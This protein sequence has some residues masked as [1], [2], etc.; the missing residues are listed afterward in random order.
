MDGITP[1][2]I[3]VIF[4]VIG[5][6]SEIKSDAAKKA[7]KLQKQFVM[8]QQHAAQKAHALRKEKPMPAADFASDDDF[9]DIETMTEEAKPPVEPVPVPDSTDNTD[10]YSIDKHDFSLEYDWKKAIVA[11]EILKTKF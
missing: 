3:A 4:I 2:I 6:V 8:Q 5:I 11:S 1:I 9:S 10:P 7:A